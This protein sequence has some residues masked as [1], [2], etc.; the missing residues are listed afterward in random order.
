M[1]DF[2]LNLY[3]NENF[4]IYLGL[5]I[6]VLVVAFFLV[7]FLGKKD[8][9]KLIETGRIP[10]LKPKKETPKE[11]YPEDEE[12]EKDAFKEIEET[13][14]FEFVPKEEP[15]EVESLFEE[16]KTLELPTLKEN[17][18]EEVPDV[19]VESF[20]SLANSIESE[21]QE[22]EKYQTNNY[23]SE[24]DNLYEDNSYDD[25]ELPKLKR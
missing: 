14:I 9:K 13:Q 21:L 4:P 20:P 17:P 22:L 23:N 7:Y 16:T 18:Q 1:K 24:P 2:I 11:E 8:F 10:R 6:I 12:Y 25:I 3:A 15:R 19:K 5:F